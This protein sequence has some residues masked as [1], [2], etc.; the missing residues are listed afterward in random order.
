LRSKKIPDEKRARIDREACYSFSAPHLRSRAC[1][2][3]PTRPGHSSARCS[4]ALSSSSIFA[5]PMCVLHIGVFPFCH[6]S[7]LT[8]LAGDFVLRLRHCPERGAPAQS[9][10]SNQHRTTSNL[11]GDCY[12]LAR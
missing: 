12:T 10:G 9:V 7:T 5:S 1:W 2:F 3:E 11:D 8:V 4:V 6:R